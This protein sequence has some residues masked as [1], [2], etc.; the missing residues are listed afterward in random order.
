MTPTTGVP[1]TTSSDIAVTNGSKT[2]DG[3]GF[4]VGMAFVGI[5]AASIISGLIFFL[6]RR[7]KSSTGRQS[8]D[9]V[10]LEKGTEDDAKQLPPPLVLDQPQE[11]NSSPVQEMSTDYNKARD[12]KNLLHNGPHELQ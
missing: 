9:V 5:A 4:K 6:M 10:A 8:A 1:A 11:L 7:K 2:T 12:E 3:V